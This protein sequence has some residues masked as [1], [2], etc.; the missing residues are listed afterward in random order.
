M[1]RIIKILLFLLLLIPLF[2]IS[3]SA[4]EDY[5]GDFREILE[6]ERYADGDFLRELLSPEGIWGEISSETS[7]ALHNLA[8]R[9]LTLLGLSV[10]SALSSLYQGR[11][12]ESARFGIGIITTLFA[13]A[14]L[15]DMFS[16]IGESMTAISSL[17]SSL[18][19]LFSAIT[20]SGGGGYS[21]AGQS[22]GMAV[23]AS[24]FSGV[25]TPIFV[26]LLSFMLSLGLLYSFGVSGAE[27]LMQSIK[28]HALLLLSLVG[29]LM[30]GTLSLQTVLASARDSAAM[31][32]AKHLAQTALP[33][34]G[35]TVSAS[36]S[37]LWSGLSLTKGVVGVGGICAII[38]VFL[39]PL[40]TLLVYKFALGI[41]SAAEGFLS[42][43]SPL[44]RVSECLDLLIGVYSISSVIYIFEIVLFIKGGVSL[45]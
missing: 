22:L 21:S 11:H 32:A 28:R 37:A 40:I 2:T 38:G 39:G 45:L 42:V 36:L 7:L 6:D 25:I 4:E 35:G 19:P 12:G 1:K 16:E 43:G 31:R 13:Y 29:T 23:T 24:L 17:F 41:I 20:L 9:L 8:P 5:I 3:A 44:P 33:V 27:R 30:I 10:L 26:A 15:I 14:G 18:I 34:V